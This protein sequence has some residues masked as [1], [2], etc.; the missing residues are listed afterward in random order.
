[1]CLGISGCILGDMSVDKRK[2]S[3]YFPK[4][5]LEEMQSEAVRLDRSLSWV[6][7]RAWKL[8]RKDI[9]KIPGSEDPTPPKA[10]Q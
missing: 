5:M 8:A 4:E 3:L 6:S 9:A 7:Q 2:Q 10:E 1:M